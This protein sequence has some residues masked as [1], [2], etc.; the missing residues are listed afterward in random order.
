[1][2]THSCP[3]LCRCSECQNAGPIIG[4]PAA[5]GAAATGATSEAPTAVGALANEAGKLLSL[6]SL[7]VYARQYLQ[8]LL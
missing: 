4:S 1:V 3:T 6:G 2:F 7:Q 8:A 5:T